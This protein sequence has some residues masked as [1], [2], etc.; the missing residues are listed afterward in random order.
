MAAPQ[1]PRCNLFLRAVGEG[2]GIEPEEFAHLVIV[3]SAL[4]FRQDDLPP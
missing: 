4:P 2:V 1:S 3:L